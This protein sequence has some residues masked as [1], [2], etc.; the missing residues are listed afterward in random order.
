MAL[1]QDDVVP[2]SASSKLPFMLGSMLDNAH[3]YGVHVAT[4]AGKAS[5]AAQKAAERAGRKA[6]RLLDELT[7]APAKRQRRKTSATSHTT[8]AQSA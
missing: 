1:S 8:R 7:K 4:G 5:P 3:P 6:D 2:S